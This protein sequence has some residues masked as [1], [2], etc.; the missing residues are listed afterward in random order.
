MWWEVN[1]D[2]SGHR[3][4]SGEVTLGERG[5]ARFKTALIRRLESTP[6]ISANVSIRERH[7]FNF[8]KFWFYMAYCNVVLKIQVCF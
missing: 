5:G 4:T 8:L 1:N 7:I 3:I 2:H 6:T